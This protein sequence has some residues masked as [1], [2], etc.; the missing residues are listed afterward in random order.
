[1]VESQ[2]HPAAATHT[3]I[4]LRLGHPDQGSGDW[5]VYGSVSNQLKLAVA[6]VVLDVFHLAWTKQG[7][8]EIAIGTTVSD[9]GGRYQLFYEP[10][11][12]DDELAACASEG[13]VNLI[14]Y[15]KSSEGDAL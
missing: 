5:R 15:A 12:V 13:A 2:I 3:E 8:R 9:A 10:P 6:N 14:V 1:L 4:N 7:L 11:T